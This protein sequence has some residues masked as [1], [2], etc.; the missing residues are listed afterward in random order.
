M[1]FILG[2]NERLGLTG[3]PSFEMGSFSTSKLYT[4]CGRTL[5]FTPSVNFYILFLL[6]NISLFSSLWINIHSI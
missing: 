6:S 1:Y 3:R 4:I 5:A 2:K